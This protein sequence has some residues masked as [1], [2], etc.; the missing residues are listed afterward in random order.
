MRKRLEKQSKKLSRKK[1]GLQFRRLNL[2]APENPEKKKRKKQ[3]RKQNK[4]YK[5]PL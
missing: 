5:T 1:P 3:L 2:K 4:I